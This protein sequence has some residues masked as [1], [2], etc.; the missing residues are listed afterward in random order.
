M[1]A[2]NLLPRVALVAA[3][4]AFPP[5]ETW[6]LQ[7]GLPQPEQVREF[8]DSF[9]PAAMQRYHIPGA[10]V[11]FVRGDQVALTRSY[12]VAERETGRSVTAETPFR[13]ASVSKT[14]TA[15]ALMRLVQRGDLTLETDV[16]RVLKRLQ[17]RGDARGVVTLAH[18]LTHTAGLDEQRSLDRA[19]SPSAAE[20][21]GAYL[22][23][24][25]P[26]RVM[27]PGV[28]IS[29]SNFGYALLANIV[30]EVSGQL[31]PEFVQREVFAPTGMLRSTFDQLRPPNDL[32]RG[33]DYRDGVYHLKPFRYDNAIGDGALM[34]TAADMGR[35][36]A[37]LLSRGELHGTRVLSDSSVTLMLTR[38]FTNHPGLPGMCLGLYESFRNGHRVVMHEG[39][40]DEGFESLL[41]LI[42]DAR[43]GLFLVYNQANSNLRIDLMRDFFDRFF[44]GSQALPAPPTTAYRLDL[45]AGEY[46]HIRHPRSI[47]QRWVVPREKV[48]VTTDNGAL[49][50]AF[51]GA[52]TAR[53]IPIADDLFRREDS[54]RLI[55]FRRDEQGRPAYLFLGI[56]AYERL[57]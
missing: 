35:F 19:V 15:A 12:G 54:D 13:V 6:A 34:T 57:R 27:P 9:M 43:M 41:F 17:L 32:A 16:S 23:R 49:R 28:V 20:P 40:M 8:L 31:F 26:A 42:P 5:D 46:G 2:P 30:E 3:G 53:W 25:M 50:I 36:L 14:L 47:P 11:S 44:P 33:Y 22:K 45:W 4:V 48:V 10:A 55:A 24:R 39:S 56:D 51:S 1:K 21:L 38:R 37:M 29:Y 52:S 7:A 18:L